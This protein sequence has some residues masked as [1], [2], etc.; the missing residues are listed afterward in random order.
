[1]SLAVL[2]AED[3]SWLASWVRG[4]YT[5]TLDGSARVVI[6]TVALALMGSFILSAVYRLIADDWPEIYTDTRSR[7]EDGLKRKPLSA[8]LLFR[9]GPVFVVAI[10]VSVI[11]DRV[12]GSAWW[13]FWLMIAFY[14]STTHGRAAAG[15]Y[16]NRHHPNWIVLLSYHV[17][18]SCVVV[19][20]GTLGVLLRSLFAPLIPLGRELSISIWAGI[21]TAVIAMLVRELFSPRERDSAVVI[22]KLKRDIGGRAWSHVEKLGQESEVLMNFVYAVVLAEAQQRPRWFRKL[23]RIG[24]KVWKRGTYGVAQVLA[25][26]PM[27]DEES[28]DSLVSRIDVAQLEAA[29]EQGIFS[30]EFHA[31]C[32]E[33]NRDLA[34]VDRIGA[35]YQ[36]LQERE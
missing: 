8:Y 18:N 7:V 28:I 2:G 11:L 30:D 21:F 6:A 1:M 3:S 16:Q 20:V 5:S 10:F 4:F 24:G 17:F 14:L 32:L 25:N 23:E 26:A 22:S 9:T 19:V 13:G 33:L 29:V 12:G 15:V 34:H 35:F 27:S 31:I 36:V